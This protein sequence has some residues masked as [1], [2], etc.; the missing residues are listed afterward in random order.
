[1][2]RNKPG[3]TLVELLVVIAIIG[4][5]IALLLPAVQS[6]RSAARRSQC[7][8]NIRQVAIGLHSYHDANKALPIG[9]LGCCWGTWL[10]PV[11]SFVEQKDLGEKYN[12]YHMYSHVLPS[13]PNDCLYNSPVNLPVTSQRIPV[14]TCPS[15]KSHES[16]G[17]T[18][19]N[20]VGNYGNTAYEQASPLGGENFGGAPFE[21][22]Y[23][24]ESKLGRTFD[25]I[26]DGLSSTL[27]LSETV[28][29][30]EGDLR[31][32]AWW[33]DGSHFTTFV[34]PNSSIPDRVSFS[35]YCRSDLMPGHP[36]G[37]ATSSDPSRSTARSNHVG[38]V[39]GSLVDGS[40]RFFSNDVDPRVWRA[41]G[42]TQGG[43]VCTLED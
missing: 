24:S 19:H 12:Y 6:A 42:S 13:V 5:L 37:L 38:G 11:L 21:H 16:W 28:Q 27:L 14:Y 8:A 4:I 20:Y 41:M 40:A 29:G 3:F 1:M 32:F 2:Q 34:T 30:D 22:V 10:V 35:E 17:V 15:D 25:D 33:G 43:E 26:T 7:M 18:K 39:H 36:C 9:S 31:G 23:H